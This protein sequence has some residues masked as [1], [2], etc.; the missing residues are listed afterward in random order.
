MAKWALALRSP[1]ATLASVD[2]AIESGEILRTHALRYTWHFVTARDIYWLV[3]LIG[4]VVLARQKS[5]LKE[6]ELDAD[7]LRKASAIFEKALAG[8]NFLPREELLRLIRAAG[9]PTAQNRAAH[10]LGWAELQQVICSGPSR[11]GVRT[12]ALLHER[13]PKAKR[14]PRDESLATLARRYFTSR[15]PATVQDFS[16]W[17]GLTLR[18]AQNGLATVRTSLDSASNGA[19]TVWFDGET[20]RGR[21]TGVHLLPAFD[22]Y[23]IGYRDRSAQLQDMDQKSLV[24]SNGIFWPVV[25]ADGA[26]IGTWKKEAKGRKVSVQVRLFRGAPVPGKSRLGAAAARVEKFFGAR[27]AAGSV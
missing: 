3:D 8:G 5:R 1:G 21:G 19:A 25:L 18:E 10:M 14:M 15:G 22:E 7:T 6:L 13:V 20:R 16:W 27:P 4:P 26:V 17:S 2:S 12:Y 9:I 11:D 23:L 24:S